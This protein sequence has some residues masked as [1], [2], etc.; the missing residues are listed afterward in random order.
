MKG[1]MQYLL[2]ISEQ[3]QSVRSSF[4]RFLFEER[5]NRF[6]FFFFVAIVTIEL[7][8]FKYFYPYPAFINGDSYVYLEMAMNNSKIGIYPIG[9]PM[10]LRLFSVFSSSDMALV[11]VQYFFV[12]IS[13]IA[14]L[15]S[16]FY[17]YTINR[18]IQLILVV[19][20]LLNPAV[21]YV[22]NYVSSDALFWFLSLC[23]F[24]SLL[25]IMHYPSWKNISIHIALVGLVFMVRYNAL[26]YPV[27]SIFGFFIKKDKF[28]IKAFG[29]ML[30]GI[31]LGG[32]IYNT[33]LQ[34]KRETGVFQ[35]SPFSGWQMANNGMYA[36]RFVDSSHRKDVPIS[37]RGIDSDVRK[38]F[39]TAQKGLEFDYANKLLDV[40]T[41][42]MWTDSSPLRIY[43]E[44]KFEKDTLITPFEKWAKVAPLYKDYGLLLMKLYPTKYARMYLLPNFVKFYAPPVEF[45]ANYGFLMDSVDTRAA[46]WFNYKVKKLSTRFSDTRVS[47][48]NYYPIISGTMNAVYI[49]MSISFFALNGRK[50]KEIFHLWLLFTLFWVC[51]LMFS[52]FASPV[53]LRFQLFP[54]V[55]CTI[56]N[57]VL[58][59]FVLSVA[60]EERKLA[61]NTQ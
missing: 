22:A 27:I 14:L 53:A 5:F 4:W 8:V 37:F 56:L 32:F 38:Y 19:V 40:S 28:F 13:I 23:W 12:Q 29:I 26:Y 41:F 34:Y 57:L 46:I 58:L 43:M 25:W 11:V 55:L 10:F 17:L 18:I 48:L 6:L 2:N 3:Y 59:D 39:D 7:L 60:R 61:I 33:S 54:L 36:Y 20:A 24:T 30:M 42:Y 15:F 51:N 44:R 47:A 1:S 9:Y 35:F 21:L 52:V 50:N 45:L 16:L 31:I 49:M